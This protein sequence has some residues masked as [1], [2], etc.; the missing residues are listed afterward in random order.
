M[1]YHALQLIA[2]EVRMIMS[3]ALGQTN[4]ETFKMWRDDMLTK[5]WSEFKS[6]EYRG[7]LSRTKV[8]KASMVDL[9]AL[10]PDKGNTAILK[11]F[12][13]LEKALQKNLPDIFLVKKS[14]LDQYNE[15]VEK[16]EQTGGKFPVD[17]QGDL[18]VIR[19][20]KNIGIQTARLNS[21]AIRE[22]LNGDIKRIGTEVIKGKTI[23][24]RMEQDIISTSSKLS[25]CR[26]DLAIAQ[27]KIDGL[28][29]QN[30]Q[31]QSEV[32]KL[33]QQSTEKDESLE[34]A[35]GS[36]RRFAL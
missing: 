11:S 14:A 34:H 33:Q 27:E 25:K 9:N 1:V 22:L 17:A 28:T 4:V 21:P 8:A 15:H 26:K 2:L 30:L 16:L 36:G 24:E 10:K 6:L 19:L 13:E 3:K 18:D 20:A 32:R 29:K 12:D 23:E 35:I 31:L 7:S 5:A